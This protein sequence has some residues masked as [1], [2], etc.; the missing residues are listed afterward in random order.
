MQCCEPPVVELT[1]GRRQRC[2]GTIE[3]DAAVVGDLFNLFLH[4]DNGETYRL[5]P[6]EVSA[7]LWEQIGEELEV[8]G[9]VYT[10][11]LGNLLLTVQTYRTFSR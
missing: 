11:E 5:V 6:N 4:A 3:G 1:L 8:V 2:R 10:D 7:A 9:I